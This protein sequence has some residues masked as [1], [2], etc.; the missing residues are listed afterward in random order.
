[1]P[2]YVLPSLMNLI[3]L[4]PLSY[5]RINEYLFIAVVQY[6][7]LCCY[8]CYFVCVGAYCSN[9]H[10]FIYVTTFFLSSWV[11]PVLNIQSRG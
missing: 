2:E 3:V 6:I 7:G 5:S 11:E 9:Y 10:F 4:K 8:F 1:M